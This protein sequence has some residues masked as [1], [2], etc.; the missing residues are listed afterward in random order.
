M[1][2]RCGSVGRA[3]AGS[4]SEPRENAELGGIRAEAGLPLRHPIG[5]LLW[6][7]PCNMARSIQRTAH[8][9]TPARPQLVLN[10]ESRKVPNADLVRFGSLLLARRSVVSLCS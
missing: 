10:Y 3:L 1:V 6:D 8:G 2:W 5:A 7:T 9:M 4:L